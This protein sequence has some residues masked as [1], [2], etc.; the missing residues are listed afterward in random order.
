MNKPCLECYYNGTINAHCVVCKG[1]NEWEPKKP[2]TKTYISTRS[3][4]NRNTL[5]DQIDKMA[6]KTLTGDLMGGYTYMRPN[7]EIDEMQEYCKNDVK[8]LLNMCF[9]T[10]GFVGRRNDMGRFK[11][12]RVIFNNPATIVIWKDGSKTVVKAEGEAF[13]EE[14]GLAMAIAKK[15]LGNEGNYYEVFKKYLPKVDPKPTPIKGK[16]SCS[17]NCTK[18]CPVTTNNKS[19]AGKHC[20]SECKIY[21]NKFGK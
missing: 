21:A 13:D 17:G 2:I 1:F 20:K 8:N 10:A 5:T 3:P 14:K 6:S 19:K 15:A 16:A 18:C 9:G 7:F 11:I 4:F 12:D